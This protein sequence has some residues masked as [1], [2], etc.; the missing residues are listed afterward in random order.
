MKKEVTYHLI[1][2]IACFVCL[3]FLLFLFGND[4]SAGSK[5]LVTL[6][7]VLFIGGVFSLI[8]LLILLFSKTN[9]KEDIVKNI[10]EEDNTGD[11]HQLVEDNIE[12]TYQSIR[13]NIIPTIS[14]IL[15][16]V[17]LILA[18]YALVVYL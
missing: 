12:K 8:K 15:G 17:V 16:I 13:D 5:N 4:K 18:T 14:I 1:S 7:V 10:K 11:I 2:V 9:N 6:G 3:F